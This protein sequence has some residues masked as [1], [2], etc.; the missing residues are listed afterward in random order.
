MDL[1]N[2]KPAPGSTEDRTRV[3]RGSG[4]GDGDSAGRGTKGQKSR[5]GSKISIYFEGG[6]MPLIRRV[7]KWGFHNPNKKEYV[8]LNVGRLQQLVDDGRL[9]AGE[10]VTPEALRAIGVLD[11]GEEVKVL[12]DGALSES[13]D[14]EAHAFSGSAKKKIEEAGG[15]TNVIT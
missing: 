2:L 12:G 1:S 14:V 6:Q 7:P 4:S 13:L 10:T 8:P 11:K 15:S 3:G 9:D 5:S